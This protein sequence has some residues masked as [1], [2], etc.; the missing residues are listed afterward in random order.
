MV[1][2]S[3][4]MA[5]VATTLALAG[6]SSSRTLAPSISGQL[7]AQVT[8]GGVAMSVTTSLNRDFMPIAPP[9]GS[10]LG[11][12]VQVHSLTGAALP[13][14]LSIVSVTVRYQGLEWTSTPNKIDLS[15]PTRLEAGSGGGPKWGP[16]VAV[17][18]VAVLE[19][20]GHRES[21]DLTNQWIGRT[22]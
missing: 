2:R 1:F 19:L 6:C 7:P 8:L 22:D 14:G 11:V 4:L 16:E 17:D 15:D 5:L 3:P 10:P 13:A 21:V 18:V 20:A 12:L 9:D